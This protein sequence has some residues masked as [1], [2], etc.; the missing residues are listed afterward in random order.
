M[1]SWAVNGP[2]GSTIA[3]LPCNQRG[4]IGLSQGL[5]TGSRHTTIRTPPRRF[6]VRLCLL[7][8]ARTA[9]LT[10]QAALSHT[11]TH[12]RL[13]SAA[14]RSAPANAP[15]H[16]ILIGPQPPIAGQS[17]GLRIVLGPRFGFQPQRPPG[18]HRR[19]RQAAPPDL[20]GIAHHPV[21]VASRQAD[22]AV[23]PVFLSAYCGSGLV[24]H[25]FARRQPTPSRL[26]ASRMVS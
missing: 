7:I 16:S 22:Q 21:G 14:S 5:F 15:Q 18:V 11:S 2:F 12:T 10:C 17:L 20:V 8:H 3:R 6:T 13:P 24:I 4:S 26:S 9:W 1:S 19:L 25:I 23:A